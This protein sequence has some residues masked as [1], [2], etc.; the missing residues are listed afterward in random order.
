MHFNEELTFVS[1]IIHQKPEPWFTDRI[2]IENENSLGL[3]E[4]YERL[5]SIYK[6]VS[7]FDTCRI[8]SA[9][10][11]KGRKFSKS[12]FANLLLTPSVL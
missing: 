4:I 1:S 2:L 10:K 3:E 11:R 9:Q 6:L 12:Y 5:Y 8:N 7:T